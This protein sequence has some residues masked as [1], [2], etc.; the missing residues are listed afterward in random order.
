MLIQFS[1]TEKLMIARLTNIFWICV[2][3]Y[4][5]NV[6]CKYVIKMAVIVIA[7]FRAYLF[8][9]RHSNLRLVRITAVY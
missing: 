9:L 4:N 8:H 3:P 1:Y 5:K 2:Y 7:L 6:C